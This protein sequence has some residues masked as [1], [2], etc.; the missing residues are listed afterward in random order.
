MTNKY[1]DDRIIKTSTFT[2]LKYVYSSNNM[3]LWYY[4]NE[5]YDWRP[6]IS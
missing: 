1:A 5:H 6:Y 3:L 2:N 4:Y